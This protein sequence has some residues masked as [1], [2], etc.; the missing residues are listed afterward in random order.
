M[1]KINSKL[2][3]KNGELEFAHYLQSL[4]FEA[5]RGQQNKGGPDSP[6]VI[7]NIKEIHFEVKR[8]EKLNLEGALEQSVRDSN[9][10]EQIP[11]VAHRKNKSKKKELTLK[12]EWIII[13]K[14]DDFFKL[15]NKINKS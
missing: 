8:T 6:D 14:A 13:L 11:V 9:G 5:K 15:Y 4:G 7:S 12:G 1:A 10:T 2:K 3:G